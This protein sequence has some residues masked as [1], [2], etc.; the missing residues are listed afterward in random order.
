M[1]QHPHQTPPRTWRLYDATAN[2]WTEETY[3]LED[4]KGPPAPPTSLSHT[5]RGSALLLAAPTTLSRPLR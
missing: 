1:P 3:T 5:H 4:L 2:T